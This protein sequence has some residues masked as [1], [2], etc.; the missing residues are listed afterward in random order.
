MRVYKPIL[1]EGTRD[2]QAHERCYQ[3]IRELFNND[4]RLFQ[5]TPKGI[6]V[7]DNMIR[8]FEDDFYHSKILKSGPMRRLEP[9]IF[10]IAIESGYLNLMGSPDTELHSRL[11]RIMF[12]MSSQIRQGRLN[13]SNIDIN[14]TTYEDLEDMFGGALDKEMEDEAK[15]INSTQ[16]TPNADYVIKEVPDFETA[17][18]YGN[19]TNPNG[20]ICYSE[21]ENVWKK[22]T[23]FGSNKV[24]IILKKGW[25]EIPP[26]HDNSVE[27]NA[28]DE[29][30]L[31]MIF[32]IVDMDGS[33]ST[34][35]VRWNHDAIYKP[36]ADVDFALTREEISQ[37][38]GYNFFAKFKP[39]SPE[40]FHE[41]GKVTFEEVDFML[42]NGIEPE[43]I[44]EYIGKESSGF[45]RVRYNTKFNFIRPNGMLL[46]P[47]RW[48]DGANDFI[49]GVAAIWDDNKGGNYL[50]PDG[51][52]LT[53]NQW[54]EL[55]DDFNGGFAEVEIDGI[56]YRLSL[57]GELTEQTN[58]KE[59]N[60][61]VI[62]R[63][64]AE[65]IK[66]LIKL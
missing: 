29:Y 53:P 2:K 54:Y 19:H 65:T 49:E 27:Y 6:T 36:G 46:S 63:L 59:I 33:L 18:F 28:Y 62:R 4:P 45:R 48:F 61:N 1:A 42:K 21:D 51:T 26:V 31:S 38:V 34:C 58:V 13:I 30:G 60:E 25:Q 22:Y 3:I 24:Y 64:V 20:R 11:K 17:N 55:A 39:F 43:E 37:L 7:I 14:T 57:S 44:F 15:R 10:E 66:N 12:Y 40:Y 23:N 35:N 8:T 32:V 41:N 52:L 5:K 56:A 16:Y 9:L 47:K 50:K